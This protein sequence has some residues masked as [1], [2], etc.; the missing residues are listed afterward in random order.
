MTASPNRS[1]W[2]EVTSTEDPPSAALPVVGV[3]VVVVGA[4]I[5]GL[6]TAWRLVDEGLS[7]AVIDRGPIGGGVTGR[8]TAKVTALHGT[9]HHTLRRRHGPAVTA[10]YADANRWGVDEISRIV[11]DEAIECGWEVAPAVT[12]TLGSASDVVESEASA[13]AE[14]GLPVRITGPDIGLP[15]PVAA[16]VTLDDQGMVNP[17]RLC[18]GLAA[19]LT[20]RGATI[21]TDC[22]ADDVE[23]GRVNTTQGPLTATTAVV[24]ATHLPFVA[25][26][27]QFA[28]TRP[29]HSYVVAAEVT[30]PGPVGMLLG[31]D[32]SGLRSVRRIGGEGNA[33]L[34]GGQSHVTGRDRDTDRHHAALERWGVEHLDFSRVTHRWSAHDYVTAKGFPSV[35]KLPFSTVPTYAVTGFGKWGFS[36]ASAAARII[37]DL[38]V[39]RAHPWPELASGIGG[40]G[41]RA[42]LETVKGNLQVAG[43]F[44]GDRIAPARPLDDLRP[45]EGRVAR[46]R[47][48][49]VA[50]HRTDDGELFVVDARCTHLGCIV[51]WN[52]ADRSWDCP[53][54][55]SRFAPDG[56]VFDG[57]ATTDLEQ[58]SHDGIVG[59]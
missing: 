12:Y 52:G 18:L 37:A 35:G 44:F 50:A 1:Y 6:L 56:T 36:N 55:G 46:L 43:R 48:R 32:D 28:T 38:V 22:A 40:A 42:A 58:R 8:S 57:P 31:L 4:G 33:V 39:G 25:R 49:R 17:R 47:G 3:D 26:G 54:H 27:G 2:M 5:A 30:Q 20:D 23:G 29:V 11:A 24:L 14:A 41:L 9:T 45:G 13:A 15:Y 19:R 59:R 21:T 7:V 10:A 51:Q 53:C 16:A 34:V